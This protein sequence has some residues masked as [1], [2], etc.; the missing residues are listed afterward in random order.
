MKGKLFLVTVAVAVFAI[1]MFAPEASAAPDPID[2]DDGKFSYLLDT[3]N[4]TA[5]IVD[6]LT[7]DAIQTIPDY[8]TYEG[9]D[10][11]VTSIDW[12]A[13][14]ADGIETINLGKHLKEIE[15]GAFSSPT[16]RE[17]VAATDMS[18]TPFY[19]D[20]GVLCEIDIDKD[21]T[22]I[23]RYPIGKAGTS[24]TITSMFNT[25]YENAFDRCTNLEEINFSSTA[26]VTI[27]SGAF[28][29]CTN[30]AR[31]NYNSADGYNHF[32]DNILIIEN[33]AFYEC[34][35]LLPSCSKA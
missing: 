12:G 18:D 28:A 25:I 2:Y 19:V 33:S 21:I 1:V 10:Y 20:D 34:T 9:E 35:S 22:A 29:G 31:I 7:D 32:P 23:V 4:H 16:L 3:T 14:S 17:F 6:S 11:N 13:F 15:A 8:V 26:I 30:L 24:Y 27:P 5:E